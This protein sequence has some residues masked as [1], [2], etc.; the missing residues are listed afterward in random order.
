MK[1]NCFL[2]ELCYN[3]ITDCERHEGMKKTGEQW[4]KRLRFAL[5]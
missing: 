3:L 5:I 1:E 4:K 2:G